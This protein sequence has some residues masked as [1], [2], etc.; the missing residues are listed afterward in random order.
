MEEDLLRR[1]SRAES[2]MDFSHRNG[3]NSHPFLRRNAIHLPEGG[4]FPGIQ[5]QRPVAKAF[6]EGAGIE[7]AVTANPLFIHQVQG[8]TVPSGKRRYALPGKQQGSVLRP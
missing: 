8:G 4:G 7:P 2:G 6:P 5:R 1:E 3:V